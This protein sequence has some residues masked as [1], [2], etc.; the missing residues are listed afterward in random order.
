MKLEKDLYRDIIYELK[1]SVRQLAEN[2][3]I[4]RSFM[5]NSHSPAWIIDEDGVIVYMNDL[6]KE[7]WHLHDSHLQSNL[8]DH[9]PKDLADEYVANNKKVIETGF[10][11]ITIENSFRTDGTPGIYLVHK[12]LLQTSY[13]KRL[14]GGQS[15]D[16]TDE[17]R[18][19]EEIVKSNER[20]FYA[21]QA[22]SDSIWDWDIEAGHIYRSE[23]FS[24]LT[25]YQQSEIGSN[26]F[27]WYDKIH[28][29]D[30]E[31]VIH[32]VNSC[33]VSH[34]SYWQDEYRFRCQDDTYK[35]FSDRGY[36]IYKNAY[37]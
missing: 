16:I 22:T 9:I 10:P 12:F 18:A 3:H 28:P 24:R 6:F 20:F 8:Y 17:R 27:W 7:V 2:E 33:I 15:I 37:K 4:F 23:S 35:Y 21:A 25:G 34:N 31:R 5:N 32:Q 30:R 14:I 19:Q 13:A 29:E 36:I 11:L 26:L 1:A